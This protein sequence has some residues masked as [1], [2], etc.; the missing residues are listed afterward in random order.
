MQ[1]A[2]DRRRFLSGR[3]NPKPDA[4]RHVSSALV[5]AFP[6]KRA[7]VIRL[8]SELP[9][10]EVHGIENGKIIVLLEGASV[11]EIGERLTA[12]SLMEGVLA[13]NLVFEQVCE[14]DS[15]ETA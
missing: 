9:R 4:I 11:G 7:E 10:T 2:V 1:Q 13:A 8:I 3:V 12:I 14:P 5:L 6:E 15:E